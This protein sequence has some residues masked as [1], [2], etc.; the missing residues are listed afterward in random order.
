M[1]TKNVG[2]AIC[3]ATT[4][5]KTYQLECWNVSTMESNLTAIFKLV[6]KVKIANSAKN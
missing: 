2:M 3:F 6:T 1:R 5:N 4:F